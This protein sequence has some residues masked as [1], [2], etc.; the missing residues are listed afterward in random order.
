MN[1]DALRVDFEQCIRGFS[2]R[3][4]HTP[5]SGERSILGGGPGGHHHKAAPEP[6]I[7][8]IMSPEEDRV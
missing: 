6:M 2:K 3:W 7:M 1:G 5:N 8:R 4:F